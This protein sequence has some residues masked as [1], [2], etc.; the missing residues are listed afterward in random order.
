MNSNSKGDLQGKHEWMLEFGTQNPDRWDMMIVCLLIRKFVKVRT[1]AKLKSKQDLKMSQ[2]VK[3][4][5]KIER[6]RFT[7]YVFT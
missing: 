5:L 4:F 1:A 7:S 6:S 3:L 2:N